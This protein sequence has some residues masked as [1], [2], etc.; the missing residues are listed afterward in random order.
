MS[1]HAGGHGG[2]GVE[3]LKDLKW[4]IFILVILWLLWFFTG[5]PERNTGDKPFIK[6]AN[7]LD[8]GETYGPSH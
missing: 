4:L 5:G 6:P 1:G 2:G 7:P 8:S 3:A